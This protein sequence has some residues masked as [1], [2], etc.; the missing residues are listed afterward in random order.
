MKR[1][2]PQQNTNLNFQVGEFILAFVM[3]KLPH[4]SAGGGIGGRSCSS[5]RPKAVKKYLVVP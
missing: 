1:V 3:G 5:C 2:P 4:E